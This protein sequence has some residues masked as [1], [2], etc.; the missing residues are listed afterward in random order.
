MPNNF[1]SMKLRYKNIIYSTILISVL[2]FCVLSLLS[3]ASWL[4]F[5]LN[6]LFGTHTG[7]AI[8]WIGLVCCSLLSI[9]LN[10]HNGFMRFVS[11]FSFYI[12]IF[13]LLFSYI[14]SGNNNLL[15]SEDKHIEFVIWLFV[16]FFPIFV[17]SVSLIYYSIIKLLKVIETNKIIL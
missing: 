14:I 12:S 1:F 5:R 13:W 7:T 3:G 10:N 11:S 6:I 8:A 17:L 15:F 2:F 9:R 4:L 16:T